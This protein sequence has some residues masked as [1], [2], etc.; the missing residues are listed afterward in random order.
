MAKQ[1]NKDPFANIKSNRVILP[2]VIGLGVIGYLFWREFNPAV[3][4]DI[5]FTWGT[6]FWLIVAVLCMVG[7]DLGYIIRI[8]V[9]S[10]GEL[11]WRQAFRVIML[12]E[13]TSAITPSAVGGTSVAI[14]YVH[15]EGIP[16]GKSSTMVLLT[17]FLDELYFAIVFPIV[18][19]IVG[20]SALF[21]VSTGSGLL[22]TGLMTFAL[23]GYFIKLT[24]VLLLGYGLFIDPRGF[25]WLVTG[26]FKLP[27]LK[28]WREKAARVGEEIVQSS[29]EMR[30]YNFKYWF[31]AGL[32]TFVSWT[33]RYFVANALIVAF[34]AVSDQ[35]MLFARQLVMWM[36]MMVMPTPGAS[37]FAEIVF[38]N[39]CSDLIS[40]PP[41]LQISAALMIAFLWRGVTYYPYLIIGAIIFPQWI[42]KSFTKNKDENPD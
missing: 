42:R 23:T 9:L 20:S 22:T 40:I 32:S 33:S 14:L 39:Y 2:I 34:F 29:V 16:L 36:M 27:F 1:K 38:S 19:L 8:R 4:G 24:W 28:R 18:L 17:S 13:A 35:F 21:D 15:K 41:E 12:W 6:L 31:N 37:G 3:F 10:R 11:T 30:G 25:K 26:V 5:H 7:R